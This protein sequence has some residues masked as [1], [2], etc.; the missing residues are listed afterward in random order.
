MKEN[1][2]SLL[3]KPTIE[4]LLVLFKDIKKIKMNN[5]MQLF[6]LK[7]ISLGSC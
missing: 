3:L 4:N 6:M 2:P 7:M 5:N 1:M